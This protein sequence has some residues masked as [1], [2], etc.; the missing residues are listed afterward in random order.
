MRI[1]EFDYHLPEQLIAQEPLAERSASRMLVVH[2]AEN[3]CEDR[4]FRDFPEY[5][6]H[7]DC[8]ILNQSKVF[9][10]RLFGKRSSGP[11]IIEVFLLR[12]V[13]D[14]QHTW[15]ALVRPGRKVPVG[16]TI[17]FAEGLQAEVLSRAEHGQ[18]IIRFHR[19][20]DLFAALAAIGH[21]PLPPYIKRADT[22]ADRDRYQTV[23]ATNIGSVAAPTAGLHFTPEILR[24]CE[25]RGATIALVTLHVGLGTFAPLHVD[26]TEEVQL[27]SERFHIDEP[28]MT[29]IQNASR[30]IAVGT[31]SVRAIETAYQTGSLQGETD[32]FISPGYQFRAIDALLT[33]FHLPKSTLLMLVSAFAGRELILRAYEHAVREQYRF[34]SYGDC[35]LLL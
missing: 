30:R 9:P 28:A 21:M 33:N 12:A 8:L 4:A 1:D 6:K 34:F 22:T 29:A 23:F 26:T 13:S 27:H 19:C 17:E 10:S 11:A 5:I 16:E 2:R 3:R 35:M 25:M 24:E 7:G 15:E 32:I 14:D 20:A 18:R 31:T